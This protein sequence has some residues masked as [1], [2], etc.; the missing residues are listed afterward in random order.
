MAAKLTAELGVKVGNVTAAMQQL[1]SKIKQGLAPLKNFEKAGKDIGKSMEPLT[2]LMTPVAATFAAAAAAAMGMGVGVKKAFSVGAEL[3]ALSARTGIAV[4]DL[5]VLQQ[6]FENVGMGADDVGPSMNRMQKA[7]SGVNEQGEPTNKTFDQL[8]L[9]MA[10]LQG[11]TPSQQFQKIGDAINGLSSPTERAAAA[12]AIFGRSGAGMLALFGNSGAMSD[13]KDTIGGQAEIME[14]NA[15]VF[16]RVSTLINSSTKKLQGIF[17]GMA[18]NIAPVLIPLLD[19]FNKIDLTSVGE[20][21][22]AAA[23]IFI[24]AMTDGSIW[25][26]LGDSALIALGNAVNF[27]W[28]SLQGVMAGLWALF[29]EEV[30]G[31]ILGFQILTSASFWKGMGEQMLSWVHRF[32]QLF[33]QVFAG[34][35]DLLKP[36]LDKVGL[37]GVADNMKG[38]FGGAAAQEGA[39]ADASQKAA[40]DNITPIL[41][42]IGSGITAAMANVGNAVADGFSNASSAIDLSGIQDRMDTTLAQEQEKADAAKKKAQEENPTKHGTGEL[43]RETKGNKGPEAVRMTAIGGLGVF[44]KNVLAKDPILEESRRQTGLLKEV[45]DGIAKLSTGGGTSGVRVFA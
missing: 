45:R 14:K 19:A 34:V 13:A 10:E 38:F 37:G 39:A 27:F 23:A 16:D 44:M 25:S 5:M 11:M 29:Q 35:A 26:I 31:V 1:S 4:G 32:N 28:A 3:N 8:G 30:K 33:Y 42:Q 17:V 2:S 24:E 15:G 36:L 7:L 9:S 20:Q 6:A 18:E 43:D 12:M 21:L 22:G 41:D 40:N